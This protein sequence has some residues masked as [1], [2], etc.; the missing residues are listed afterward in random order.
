M[1]VIDWRID[2]DSF[3]FFLFF[4]VV[5]F[6]QFRLKGKVCISIYIYTA[7]CLMMTHNHNFLRVISV[8]CRLVTL[9]LQFRYCQSNATFTWCYSFMGDKSIFLFYCPQKW[10][11]SYILYWYSYKSSCACEEIFMLT[12]WWIK[13][14][15][16]RIF[17]A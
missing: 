2:F 11:E 8:I 5:F 4:F 3:H 10:L 15:K 7:N 17:I 6:F 1:L 9:F 12:N 16:D 14:K 13:A